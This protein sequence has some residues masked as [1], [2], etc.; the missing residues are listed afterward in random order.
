[1][2]LP[3]HDVHSGK[4]DHTQHMNPIHWKEWAVLYLWTQVTRLNLL[5]LKPCL[6]NS[7]KV[8][9]GT[10]TTRTLVEANVSAWKLCN[11]IWL[12][13]WAMANAWAC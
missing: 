5:L 2:S 10:N 12:N 7:R 11:P 6:P 1:M 9:A 13:P 3:A 4:S 8:I